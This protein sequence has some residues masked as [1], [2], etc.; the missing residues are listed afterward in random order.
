MLETNRPTQTPVTLPSWARDILTAHNAARSAV[1]APPLQWNPVLQEHATARA[2]E[3]AQ[4]RQLVHAPR[5]GRGTERE[6]I[7]SAPISYSP[8]QMM[9]VWICEQRY[10]RPG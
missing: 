5:E 6:N 9:N 8:G 4:L 3:M 1:G 10:F 7:L 2:G